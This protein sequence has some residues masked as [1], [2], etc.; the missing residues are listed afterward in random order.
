MRLRLSK[1]VA[2]YWRRL[3]NAA[4]SRAEKSTP[5]SVGNPSHLYI[6]GSDVPYSVEPDL[7]FRHSLSDLAALQRL[8]ES[9]GYDVAQSFGD[10]RSLAEK[11][12]QWRQKYLTFIQTYPKE[13]LK[14]IGN[15]TESEEFKSF[16]ESLRVLDIF[17]KEAVLPCLRIP[18]DLHPW[19]PIGETPK[20]L[21]TI[22][23]GRISE[24]GLLDLP[25]DQGVS[26]MNVLHTIDK[27]RPLIEFKQ[28]P[29]QCF[30]LGSA[31]L[32]LRKLDS[33]FVKSLSD[34]AFRPLS[35]AHFARQSMVEAYFG[36]SDDSESNP[37]FLPIES[38]YG[39]KGVETTW[40]LNLAGHGPVPYM[41]LFM[42]KVLGS[43]NVFPLK[44][45]SHGAAYSGRYGD[46]AMASQAWTLF[47]FP[48][49]RPKVTMFIIFENEND[50]EINDLEIADLVK[51]TIQELLSKLHLSFTIEQR[52]SHR[53][54]MSEMSRLDFY[55][56]SANES[57]RAIRLASVSSHGNF[58]SR[59]IRL[60]SRSERQSKN[61]TDESLG[62]DY[63]KCCYAEIELYNVLARLYEELYSK[64][65]DPRNYSDDTK[66]WP[67]VLHDGARS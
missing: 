34:A 67:S 35:P 7:D 45:F 53:L 60:T 52:P 29:P 11:Y 26:H 66:W 57:T 63:P 16:M 55:A 22:V 47:N 50:L 4:L 3:C 65:D 38:I 58:L 2:G 31:A 41:A 9:R 46:G 25:T 62:F 48:I 20:R 14:D 43:K 17:V 44:F 30:L 59:R 12:E 19:T 54:L 10:L 8:L 64:T 51:T 24:G 21:T 1:P 49:Q 13:R 18:V 6:A 15:D 33:F 5:S 56:W 37:H 28:D 39:E 61:V 32:L 42:R 23:G 27:Q 40:A 36:H